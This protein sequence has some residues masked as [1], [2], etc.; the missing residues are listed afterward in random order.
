MKTT[1]IEVLKIDLTFSI[2]RFTKI[3]IIKNSAE[4]NRFSEAFR[5]VDLPTAQILQ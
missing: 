4:L 5:I 3:A 2:K 1:G